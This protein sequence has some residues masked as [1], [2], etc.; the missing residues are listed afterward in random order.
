MI[1]V[2]D[3]IDNV[4]AST[5]NQDLDKIAEIPNPFNTL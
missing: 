4:V 5:S 3:S 2:H 1:P